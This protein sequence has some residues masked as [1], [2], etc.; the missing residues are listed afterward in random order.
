MQHLIC[1]HDVDSISPTLVFVVE[2]KN[3]AEFVSYGD[4][5]LVHASAVSVLRG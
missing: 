3:V 2:A 5:Y 1:F 4:H